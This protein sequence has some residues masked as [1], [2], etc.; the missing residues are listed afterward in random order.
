[1]N[2]AILIALLAVI[3]LLI[4]IA[5]RIAKDSPDRAEL[6]RLQTRDQDYQDA[7]RTIREKSDMIESLQSERA[8]LSAELEHERRNASEKLKLLEDSETRLKTDFEN[9]ANRIFEEKG[10][11]LT[12]QN[13][14]RMAGLLQPFKEQ[15]ESFRNRV[16]EV[17]KNGTQQSAQLL[18]QV[19]QLQ[20]LSNKVSDDANNLAHAI[21]GDSKKQGDWGEVIVERIFEE[22][23]LELGREFE[24]Q[25][26]LRDEAGALKKPDFIVHLPGDKSVIVDSKVSLTAYERY[27]SADDEADRSKALAEHVQSVRKHMEELCEKDYSGLLGGKSLDFV[28]MCIPLEP[29]YQQALKADE[30]LIYDL[31]K[32]NVVVTGPATL[33]ITIKL[34]AQIWRR[35]RE[36]RNAAVIA[37]RAGRMYDQVAL[38][39]DAMTDARRKLDGVSESFELAMMRLKGGRGNLV[40]RVEKIRKLGAK[41]N[42]QIPPDIIDD[43][44]ADEDVEEEV[45]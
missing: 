24:R 14:E 13:R 28:M 22:S 12:E 35:E 3:A 41:V 40:G 31:G 30:N 45:Q 23:G 4:A 18:E 19:R 10:R 25:S 9:L 20:E 36:N 11:T 43:A 44:T 2:A 1:M 8:K 37:D 17:H 32:T 6:A 26:G 34:I 38:I 16:D 29:A 33:M 21:K 39:V 7:N 42:K 27:C 15:L 5:L